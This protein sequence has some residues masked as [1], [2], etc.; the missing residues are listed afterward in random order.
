MKLTK[1]QLQDQIKRSVRGWNLYR[2]AQDRIAEHCIAVYGVTPGDVDADE[3][4]DAIGGGG[5]TASEM[6]VEEFD[7]V[8]KQSLE[9]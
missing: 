8:M 3:I 9:R 7:R 2:E 4:I 5:G 1:T 6:S